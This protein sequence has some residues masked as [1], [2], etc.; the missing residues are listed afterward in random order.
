MDDLKLAVGDNFGSTDGKLRHLE[1]IVREV[2][3]EVKAIR[4]K[5]DIVEAK[6]QIAAKLE[7]EQQVVGGHGTHPSESLQAASAPQQSHHQQSPFPSTLAQLPSQSFPPPHH[8]PQQNMPSQA[9]LPNQQY[10][11]NQI[12]PV[13]PRE[14]YAPAPSLTPEIPSQL[15]QMPLSQQIQ[16]SPLHHHH[17][18]N[19]H[20]N[21][22][23]LSLLNQTLPFLLPVHLSH[24]NLNLNPH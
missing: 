21:F 16:P 12:S 14:S 6:T 23:T 13:P 1:N 20:L 10:Q 7:V 9:Q 2:H 17:S 5:Q 24:L 18:I 8:H 19:Q 22:S 4:D 3:T 15:Y 11:L